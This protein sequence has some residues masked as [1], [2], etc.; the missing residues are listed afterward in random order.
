MSADFMRPASSETFTLPA[1]Y[2]AHRDHH[3]VFYEAVRSGKRPVEDAVFGGRAGIA[4][5]CELLRFA[6]GML[7][8]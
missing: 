3:R 6:N 8:G 4:N 5:Q 7:S 2:D 1:G